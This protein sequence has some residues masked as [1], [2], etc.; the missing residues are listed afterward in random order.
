[1]EIPNTNSN[2]S[3]T[4]PVNVIYNTLCSFIDSNIEQFPSFLKTAEIE[5]KEHLLLKKATI[6]QED[7]ITLR[8]GR[9]FNLLD[10]PFYFENQT[11]TPETNAT[12]DIGV[13]VKRPYSD[14]LICFV[15]AKRLPTPIGNNREETEYVYY[16][17]PSK[18]GGIERFKTEKHG[19][20]EKFSFSFMLGYIQEYNADYWLQQVDNWVE[21]QKKM[22]SNSEIN[23][24]EKD[25][26]SHDVYF[27]KNR[28][29]K[30]NS[31]HSRKTLEEIK[32]IHYWIDLTN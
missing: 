5:N 1:M 19:G 2:I 8:L 12:T 7:D 15:E 30:Y 29:T 25:K 21:N 18:Q 13:L 28:I 26:L 31:A 20:A 24:S 14:C 32:L 11:K 23:W 22:S 27:S 16:D 6:E 4:L 9:Y 3:N 10:S 17:S